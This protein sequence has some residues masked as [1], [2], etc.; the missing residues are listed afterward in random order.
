[1]QAAE[2]IKSVS[3]YRPVLMR[4]TAR[5]AAILV[6]ILNRHEGVPEIVLTKRSES[7]TTYAGQ[8]SFPGGVRSEEDRDLYATAVRET[9]EELN[10]ANDSYQLIGQLDDFHDRKGNLVRPFVVIMNKEEF[11]DRHVIA[12][13][14]IARLYYFSLARL[15]EIKDDPELHVIT[16]RKP[17]YSFRDGDVFVWGLTAGILVHLSNVL[18]GDN[19]PLGKDI[20]SPA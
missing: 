4:D 20:I 18:N 10:L 11:L 2:I 19:R 15:D 14:E 6:M 13:G 7:L 9:M 16:R 5:Q 17:S 3:S 1:M 12:H 8:Y